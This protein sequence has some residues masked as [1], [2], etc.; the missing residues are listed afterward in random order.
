MRLP[1]K[2]AETGMPACS[3][4]QLPPLPEEYESAQLGDARRTQRLLAIVERL[5]PAPGTS[6]PLACRGAAELEGCYRLLSNPKVAWEEVL[7]PHV[8]QSLARCQAAAAQGQSLVVAHDTTNVRFVGS[9]AGVRE[10]LGT[11]NR[12]E[13]GF[14]AHLALACGLPSPQQVL[15]HPLGV[16]GLRPHVRPSRPKRTHAQQK[17]ESQARP[18]GER[19][20]EMWQTLAHTV[21]QRC[22]EAGVPDVVHV[23]DQ[24]ADSFRLFCELKRHGCAF[25]IR[26]HFNRLLDAGASQTDPAS[27]LH[28]AL[29]AAPVLLTREVSL[30]ATQA[31]WKGRTGGTPAKKQPAREGRTAHLQ[32]RARSGLVLHASEYSQRDKD[33]PS[34][35]TLNAVEVV[36]SHPPEGQHA[37]RWV[38]LTTLPVDTPEAVAHV[39]DCYRARWSVEE[40]FKALKT[41]CGLEKRQLM[42]LHALLNALA[43]LLPLAWRLLALRT[44]AHQAPA[45]PAS[46]LFNPDE[47]ALLRHLSVRVHLGPEPTCAEALLALAGLGG[48]LKHNGRPGWQTLARGQDRLSTALEGWLAARAAPEFC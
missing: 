45:T 18:R 22:T 43:L 14:E 40:F 37:V 19:E 4:A 27:T 42:S 21:Q 3:S 8:A 23:M 24:E 11:L 31:K 46:P 17:K 48:H 10:G 12:G 26:T 39:V 28:A 1:K 30:G 5:A 33:V 2:P 32:V 34:T 7:A 13:S 36:E 15:A 20:S 29:E 41:G 9:E 6:F 44:L 38:L 16:V 47:L 25:V 35:L